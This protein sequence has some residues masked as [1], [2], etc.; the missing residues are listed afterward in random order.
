MSSHSRERFVFLWL[1]SKAQHIAVDIFDLHFVGPG[2]VRWLVPDL[3][4]RPPV[5]LEQRVSIFHANP[6]SSTWRSLVALAQEEMT[7]TARHR[8]KASRALPIELEAK[9]P[10]VMIDGWVDIFYAQDGVDALKSN[11]GGPRF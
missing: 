11:W 2:I 10:H 1:R 8:P 9:H 7:L 6:D 5:L 4:S 3:R